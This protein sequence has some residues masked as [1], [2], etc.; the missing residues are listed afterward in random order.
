VTGTPGWPGL[1]E[2]DLGSPRSPVAPVSW[3]LPSDAFDG[4]GRLEELSVGKGTNLYFQQQQA[5]QLRELERHAAEQ[6]GLPLRQLT[7]TE[8]NVL[9]VKDPGPKA[10]PMR[11]Q[12]PRPAEQPVEGGEPTPPPVKPTWAERVE[13]DNERVRAARRERRA[14]RRER[15]QARRDDKQAAKR[16]LEGVR[17]SMRDTHRWGPQ[18]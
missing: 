8:R 5:R 2:T 12:G 18:P 10:T 9:G 13:A 16:T 15:T 4:F 11:R 7:W 3:V 17:Q 14:A 1:G 6:S